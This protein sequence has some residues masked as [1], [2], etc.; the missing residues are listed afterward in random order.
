MTVLTSSLQL[1]AFRMACISATKV[2]FSESP[3]PNWTESVRLP[4]DVLRNNPSVD[5]IAPPAREI[6]IA[7]RWEG[8]FLRTNVMQKICDLD[9]KSSFEQLAACFKR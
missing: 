4:V 7:F 8:N 5:R 1:T 2:A 9:P 6:C 3:L